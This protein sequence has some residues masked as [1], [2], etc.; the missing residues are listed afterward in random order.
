[1]DSPYRVSEGTRFELVRCPA[2]FDRGTRGVV[3]CTKDYGHLPG[4][5]DAKPGEGHEAD[6]CFWLDRSSMPGTYEDGFREGIRSIVEGVPAVVSTGPSAP[7][8]L[9][10]A[11]GI[12][13][14]CGIPRSQCSPFSCRE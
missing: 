11:Q 4:G 1:M 6:G 5:D 8:V 14:Y 9:P 3:R 2:R 7:P 13:T 12:C 10:V